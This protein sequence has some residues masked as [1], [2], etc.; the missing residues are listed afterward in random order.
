LLKIYPGAVHSF[1]ANRPD[2][3]YFGHHLA[4]DAKAAEDSFAV[5]KA[6]LDSHLRPGPKQ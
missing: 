5:T 2:R 1:E 6:F 4:Y 3:V